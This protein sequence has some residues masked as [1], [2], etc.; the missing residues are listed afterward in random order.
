L[1]LQNT[2][3]N[4]DFSNREIVRLLALLKCRLSWNLSDARDWGRFTVEAS[5]TSNEAPPF[6]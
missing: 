5:A 4:I 1:T 6:V 3:V 2:A